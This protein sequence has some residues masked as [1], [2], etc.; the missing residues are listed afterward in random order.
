MPH[1]KPIKLDNLKKDCFIHSDSE[2]AQLSGIAPETLSRLRHGRTPKLETLEQICSGFNKRLKA[3][4]KE[5]IVPK[6]QRKVKVSDLI[7]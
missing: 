6:K 1:L 5:R 4:Q 2:L 7:A 3:L